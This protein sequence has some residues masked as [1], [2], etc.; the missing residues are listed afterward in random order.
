MMRFVF[1]VLL[2]AHTL[3]HRTYMTQPIR[4]R[5][6]PPAAK[7]LENFLKSNRPCRHLSLLSIYLSR[8]SSCSSDIDHNPS[9]YHTNAGRTKDIAVVSSRAFPQRLDQWYSGTL[10]EPLSVQCISTAWSRLF[11]S[12][13][14]AHLI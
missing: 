2:H 7:F 4:N 1:M 3:V 13:F 9:N 10:R 6:S 11:F 8:L 12:F 5:T 14:L